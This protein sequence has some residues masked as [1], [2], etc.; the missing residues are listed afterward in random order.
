M[1]EPSTDP[2]AQ[3]A[4]Q[5][6]AAT[7]SGPSGPSESSGPRPVNVTALFAEG[8]AKS[9]LLWVRIPETGASYA[10]WHGMHDGRVLLVSGPG[11]QH[12]PDLPDH[13]H[14]VLRS[15]DTWGRLLVV[16]GEVEVLEPGT[17]GW[18]EAVDVLAP[19]R[20]NAPPGTAERWAR[21]ATVRAV[22]PYGAAL[23][24]PGAFPDES[25]RILVRPQG[26]TTV[27]RLPWHRHG[28]PQRRRRQGPA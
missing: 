15:K 10:V 23:E 9:G 25:G 2:A 21:D 11:E 14:L 8:A 1:T 22:T 6:S 20:L 28:R 18:Q 5:P 17:S 13:V 26:P 27:G 19:L 12:L 16:N 4:P 3:T 7:S 24:A